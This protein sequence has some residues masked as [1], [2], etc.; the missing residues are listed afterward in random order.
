MV[1]LFCGRQS[2]LTAV[3][4]MRRESNITAN[5]EDLI[6]Q[7]GATNSMF[8]DN[9]KSQIGKAVCEIMRMYATKD[10]QSE[11]HH[12]HPNL[13]DHCKEEFK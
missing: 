10:Y 6:R 13:A 2:L 9:A 5:L 11:P 1:Q 3:Y 4:P 8:S 7:Y 12:Q